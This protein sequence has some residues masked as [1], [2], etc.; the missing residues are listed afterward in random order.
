MLAQLL[1]TTP[2]QRPAPLRWLPRSA[3]P[4]H[5]W[6]H[7]E[8]GSSCL[9]AMGQLVASVQVTLSGRDEDKDLPIQGSRG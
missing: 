3:M 8:Q 6:G 4:P 5:S 9:D 2:E 1:Q 7:L